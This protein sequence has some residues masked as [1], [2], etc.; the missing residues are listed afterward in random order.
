MLNYTISITIICG[1]TSN[2]PYFDH[3]TLIMTLTLTNDHQLNYFILNINYAHYQHF[4][5][6]LNVTCI[7]KKT[8]LL[9]VFYHNWENGGHLGS[10]LGLP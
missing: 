6:Y 8:M 7:N 2:I 4:T 3:L 5:V 10:H 1:K 9:F